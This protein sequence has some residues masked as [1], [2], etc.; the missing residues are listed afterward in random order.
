MI[1]LEVD[2][3][4]IIMQSLDVIGPQPSKSQIMAEYRQRTRQLRPDKSLKQIPE[5]FHELQKA[6]N[7]L[8]DDETSKYTT[9]GL[10]A[11]SIFLGQCGSKILTT[12]SVYTGQVEFTV[13]PSL[14][15]EK[16]KRKWKIHSCSAKEALLI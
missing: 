9:L 6:N 16:E 2:D 8:T 14:N 7:I 13:Y 10:I 15:I 12:F 1:R 4:L 3:V 5:I 11:P